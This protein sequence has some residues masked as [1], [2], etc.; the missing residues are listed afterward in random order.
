MS[1]RILKA[2]M[3]LFAIIARPSSEREERKRVVESFLLHQLNRELVDEYLKVFDAYYYEYQE[4]QKSSKRRVKRI[5]VGSVKVLR[6]CNDINRELHQQQK[7]V[8]LI[9]LLEFIK[10]DEAVITDQELVFVKT[11]S[12]QFNIPED[13]YEHLKNFVLNSIEKLPHSPNILLIDNQK[14]PPRTDSKHI[15]SESL[16]GQIRILNVPSTNMQIMR[17][18]G[19]N[20]LYLNGQLIYQDKAYVLTNGSS[21]RGAKVRPIYYSDIVSI[22]NVDK[23]K[24]KIVF[25]ANNIEYK[26]PGNKYG[27]HELSFKEESGRMVGIIGASGAGKST[28]L[29]VLNGTYFPSQG[30]IFINDKNIHEE[31][32]KENIE[33]LIGHVS[34]DD[35]LIEELTVYQNIY[36]NAKLCFGNYTEEEILETVDMVLRNLGLMEIKH[37]RVGTPLNKQISGGQRKRLNIALELIRE[38]AIMF[39]DEP[40]S[41]LSSRDSENIM[42][43]LKELALKGK[44]VIV[45]IHQPSSDIFK[46]FDRLLVLDYEGYLIYNGDPVESVS[47]FKSRVQQADSYASECPCCGNVNPEQIFN[48][49]EAQVLDEYGNITPTRKI[50][51][52]EWHEYYK[53][54]KEPYL[55]VPKK[56]NRLQLPEVNFKIPNKFRQLK[57]FVAR[58]VLSKIA[59]SQYIL[60]N[61]L[62]VPL[63]A[64]L[65]SYIIKYRSVLSG[66]TGVYELYNNENLPV[67]I[68][69]AVIIAIFVGLTVSAEEIIKD[70]KI[71]RR[72]SFLDLSRSS[73]LLSKVTIMFII[74]AIQALLFV[75]IGNTIMEI[76][77]MYLDYWLILFSTWAFSN[78]LGLIISDSF[79][80]SVTI[81]IT[82]PFLVIP[83]IILSGIIVS[84]DKLNPDISSPIEIPWYGEIITARWAYEGLAVQQFKNNAYKEKFY[85]YDR[86]MSK[87]SYKKDFWVKKLQNNI[88]SVKRNYNSPD[89]TEELEE[90]LKLLRNEI[91]KELQRNKNIEFQYIDS[92]YPDKITSSVIENTKKY[93]ESLWNYYNVRYNKANKLKDKK[94]QQLQKE[95]GGERLTELRKDH[96]NKRLNEFVT[97]SD[98]INRIVTYKNELYQEIDP[99]YNIPDSGFIKAHF[100]APSKLVFGRKINT[101]WVNFGVIW[102]MCLILYLILYFKG[103]QKIMAVFSFITMR[104]PH[105]KR[106]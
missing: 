100:Y 98:N 17:Y 106:Q 21:I 92:L 63:L 91:E 80:S 45:V 104:L 10:S 61:L 53:T 48:I 86:I 5:A 96:T 30:N 97:S 19:E 11:V 12:D 71:L 39:L 28:L 59:S 87:A 58:D 85:V 62:E 88:N 7:I 74:S 55:D 9:R 43:L 26:F 101:F 16:F 65:L 13:E 79:K 20:E 102:F 77:G 49:V 33:G 8:V 22:F 35:L 78:I 54:Y 36:Y 29:N 1:E 46:M 31:R 103:L 38:P 72:E 42:D 3:Q 47:Y 32:D 25:E 83:Q 57:V 73:Y 90:R 70:R 37:M 44:L 95:M 6:I 15:Y 99:I 66:N 82:I 68:F 93:F 64:F 89:N 69:M 94:I 4:K 67:Y 76:K 24:S 81:Y 50:T 52:K 34:Q 40:T 84:F 2:L 51:P 60:I 23:I 105:L 14:E 41:G 56:K 75:V 18:L 27:L